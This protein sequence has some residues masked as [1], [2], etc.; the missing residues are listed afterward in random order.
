M[1]GGGGRIAVWY[2][3]G[4]TVDHEAVVA[5]GG[6]RGIVSDVP[7]EFTGTTSVLGGTGSSSWTPQAQAG[8]VVFLTAA[9]SE[10]I[11]VVR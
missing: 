6:L 7:V 10:T 5:S 2:G 8:T 1:G 3:L 9:P 4:L 11:I